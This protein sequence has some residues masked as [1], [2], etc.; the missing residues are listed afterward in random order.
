VR[1]AP[2]PYDQQKAGRT[3]RLSKNDVDVALCLFYRTF[4]GM[5]VFKQVLPEKPAQQVRIL[6]LYV[7]LAF[8]RVSWTRWLLDH[9]PS[10]FNFGRFHCVAFVIRMH[11]YFSVGVQARQAAGSQ[12]CHSFNSISPQRTVVHHWLGE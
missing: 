5:L 8:A 9:V 12:I 11:D 7:Y 6:R 3:V 1:S 10:V 4:D 2:R